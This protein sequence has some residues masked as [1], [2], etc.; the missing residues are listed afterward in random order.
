MRDNAVRGIA[1]TDK[2]GRSAGGI[3]LVATLLEILAMAHHPSVST[4]D[5]AQAALQIV[6]FSKFAALIHCVLMA[7]M[8]LVVYGFSEFSLRRGLG[9]PLIRAGAI[10]YG[11]GVIAMLGAALV[12]GFVLPD[13]ASLTRHVTAIDLQIN[14]QLFVL[15]RVLNQTCASF[16]VVAMSV[17]IVLWSIDLLRD[18]GSRRMVAVLGLL[19]GAIPAAAL[20]GGWLH[21]DVHGMTQVS[22][23][24]GCWNLAV[25]VLLMRASL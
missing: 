23:L 8:L 21:L 20:L 10:A 12:S 14:E 7:L 1:I 3:L 16:A 18:S 25:A 19:A 17:G 5:I 24:Q 9:R 2:A 13:L 11:A 15:C 6:R 4:P 22:V